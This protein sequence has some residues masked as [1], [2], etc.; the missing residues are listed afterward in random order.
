[1]ATHTAPAALPISRRTIFALCALGLL[2]VPLIAMQFTSEVNWTASDFAVA[3]ALIGA[4]WLGIEVALRL[5][6]T[7]MGRALAVGAC[8]LA[9]LTVWVELAVGIFN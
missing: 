9:F 5:V 7:P 4:L 6:R 1:M 8:V 2:A 3:A